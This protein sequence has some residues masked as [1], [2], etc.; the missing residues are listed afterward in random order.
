MNKPELLL[1]AG[2]IDAFYAAI[3]GGAN[4]VYLGLKQFNARG[5]AANFLPAQLLTLVDIARENNVK[6][7]VTLNTV[8]KNKELPDLIDTL[9][10]L[11]KAKVSAVIIQDWGSWYV[12][13]KYFPDLVFHASTQMANHNSVG[14]NFSKSMGFE[15]V[16]LARELTKTELQQIMEKAKAEVEIFIHGALCYSFSGM[17]LFSSYLGGQGANRG[18][19]AQP[20]RRMF[21]DG[22]KDRFIFSL[23]DNQQLENIKEFTDLGIASLK[24]EGRMK[25]AEYVYRVASAYRMTIDHPENKN[26]AEQLLHMDFGRDKTEYFMG[27]S[28]SESISQ[29]PLTG[30][31]LDQISE[32]KKGSFKIKSK[33]PLELRYRL[34]VLD[35]NGSQIAFKIKDLKEEN[36]VYTIFTDKPLKNGDKVFLAGMPEKKFPT[37]F[38]NLKHIKNKT[39]PYKVKKRLISELRFQRG[40]QKNETYVRIDSLA[41]LRK[42]RLEE[43]D[44]LILSFSKKELEELKLDAPFIKRNAHKIFFELPGYIYENQIEWYKEF[45]TKVHQ[46]GYKRFFISH[47]SQLDLLPAKSLVACNERVYVFNDAAAKALELKNI[48]LFTFPVENDMENLLAGS[49]RAGIVPVYSTPELFYSRMPVKVNNEQSAFKD[50]NGH[51]YLRVV[52]DGMTSVFPNIPMAWLH[53]GV[54]LKKEGFTRFLFDFRGQSPSKH[55][56]PKLLKKF[57]ASEQIQPS[58]TFNYKRGL[59]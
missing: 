12:L 36:G 20:C 45:L 8:I 40:K 35:K 14:V 24:I 39:L 7:Y 54:K 44:Y 59:A 9:Y 29:T 26:E 3:E 43:L 11:S 16:I 17:C 21:N 1:P 23:K 38:E 53:Y 49:N 41:W 42:L 30:V 19:C 4:A 51:D 25:S 58:T 50:D 22:K 6:V 52:S 31:Y 46:M 48:Q 55:L 28:V 15:R 32:Y 27:A 10:F 33:L 13:N 37:K 18:Q 56:F 47:F 34:R 5:R 2:S 57:K